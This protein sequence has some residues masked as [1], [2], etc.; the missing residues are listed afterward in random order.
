MKY[1]IIAIYDSG[2][3]WSIKTNDKEYTRYDYDNE[4]I[5][6]DL[7]DIA[8]YAI[9]ED[10]YEV[11]KRIDKYDFVIISNNEQIEVLKDEVFN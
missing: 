6:S 9:M 11:K 1:L 8:E 2:Y 4:N 7:I 3:G 10:Y 5:P